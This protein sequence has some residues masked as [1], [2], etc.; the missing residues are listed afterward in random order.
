MDTPSPL[1]HGNIAKNYTLFI[2]PIILTGFLQQFYNSAD[3]MIVG[4]FAK[5]GATALAAVGSTASL[6]GLIAT[7]F[8]N[9]S[10]GT[11]VVCARMCGANDHE[12]LDRA[13][14]TSVLMGILF[15]IPLMLIG[16]LGS[17]Y[18][19]ELMGTPNN[20][21]DKATLYMR[22]FFVGAP[23]NLVYFFASATLRAVG[24][25]KRPLYIL[26][27][28]GIVNVILNIICVVGF[29]LGVSGVAIGTVASQ[30]V[31]AVL[32]L[33]V[34]SKG[35]HG[36]HF[37]FSKLKIHK[38]EFWEILT[39]GVP[40]GFNGIL[41]NLSN[42]FIQSAINSFGKTTMAAHS[43]AW[44]Y[45]CFAFY[46][47]NS[48]E[49]G[50]VCFVGQNMGAKKYERIGK[51][52]KT[53]IA[54]TSFLTVIFSAIVVVFGKPLLSVF[55]TDKEVVSIGMVQIY[56]AISIYVLYV[57]GIIFG[58]ALRG[59]GKSMLPTLIN[60]LGICAVRIGW[61]SF[62]WPLNPTLEM[63]YYSFPVTWIASGLPMLVMYII[64]KRKLMKK[65]HAQQI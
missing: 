42:V 55:T 21:I 58:G 10:V 4:N 52:V 17:R 9:L 36:L 28:S 61:I 3:S 59:M 22:L 27:L 62:V 31:S 44:N 57:P 33:M 15:G 35:S 60:I 29:G 12:G 49:Q 48:G 39:I 38:K 41:F 18:L 54:V 43:V 30:I 25:T 51:I 13:F 5:N 34:F 14:H 11:N 50:V 19:L 63:V 26:A 7:F 46:F 37:S 47:A 6:C 53:A 8:T 16:I 45:M 32:V 2:I 65:A 64:V 24:D 40:A 20:V 1:T 56:S 23:A